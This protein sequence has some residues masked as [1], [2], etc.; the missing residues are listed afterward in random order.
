[1]EAEDNIA[2]ELSY[3][4]TESIS[5]VKALRVAD[6]QLHH[7]Q[8]QCPFSFHPAHH[9]TA[10]H[11]TVSFSNASRGTLQALALIVLSH[12][13]NQSDTETQM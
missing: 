2:R 9:C 1:M 8:Q 12:N 6:H 7:C 5:R 10:S 3:S 4:V 13:A 11:G